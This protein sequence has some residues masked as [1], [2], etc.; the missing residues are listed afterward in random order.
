MFCQWLGIFGLDEQSIRSLLAAFAE[1][2]PQGSIWATPTEMLFI[3]STGELKFD[4][5]QL[6][7]RLSA[8]K[9]VADSLAFVGVRSIEELFGRYVCP[10]SSLHT[11]LVDVEPNR[12]QMLTV[13]YTGWQAFYQS[14][15]WNEKIR[16]VLVD[17]H[18]IDEDDFVLP[19]G[20]A[21]R[22]FTR[23]NQEWLEFI[24]PSRWPGPPPTD[25]HST[26]TSAPATLA[27]P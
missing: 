3:G 4:V 17:H 2:F 19:A 11:Y 15:R 21:E 24:E 16:R 10:V 14:G 6:R 8:Q 7:A 20:D 26:T 27:A 12:D 18:R 13:Q 9:A 25:P 1:S 22:F 5:P 23:V